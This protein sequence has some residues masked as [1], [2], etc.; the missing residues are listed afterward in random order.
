MGRSIFIT[1]FIIPNIST[2]STLKS[3]IIPHIVCA[4]SNPG[5]NLSVVCMFVLDNLSLF[6]GEVILS[7]CVVFHTPLIMIMFGTCE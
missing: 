5:Y 6:C 3:D 7:D 2:I 4:R 1:I